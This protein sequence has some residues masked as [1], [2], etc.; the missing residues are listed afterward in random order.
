MLRLRDLLSQFCSNIAFGNNFLI[1]R[2]CE[3][4]N[5]RYMRILRKYLS[6]PLL[7]RC[8]GGPEG[9]TALPEVR[10]TVNSRR[11]SVG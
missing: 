11:Y 9:L 7:Y 4:K 1:F 10:L 3:S 8:S 5:L 6:N 2:L